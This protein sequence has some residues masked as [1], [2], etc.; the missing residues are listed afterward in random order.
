MP[1]GLKSVGL[2]QGVVP[3]QYVFANRVF[4]RVV[5]DPPDFT[6][7]S[8]IGAGKAVYDDE[9]QRFLLTARPRKA[10]GGVRGFAANIYISGDG[11]EFTLLTSISQDEVSECSGF[12]VHSIEGTQLLRD[13]LTGR[14]HL[15]LSVDAGA[16]FIWGGL[17]WQTLLLTSTDLT[18]PW[19]AEGLVLKN[20]Q[21]YDANQARDASID[22]IDGRWVCMYKAM[23][24]K[25]TQRPALAT[26]VDGIH[27][28]KHGP[29]TIDGVDQPAFLNG[30]MFAGTNGPLFMGVGRLDWSVPEGVKYADEYRIGHAD[31]PPRDFVAYSLDSRNLDLETI[32]R[33]PWEPLS[34][35]EHREHPL[36]GYGSLVFDP[37]RNR[38]LIYVEAI[39]GN[40][41]KQIG[42]NE[43]VERLL[44]YETKL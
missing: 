35:Y 22:I 7:G 27:W 26:S 34:P 38:M 1:R 36:L 43:T 16:D 14:W 9:A 10:A 19:R 42:L 44:L 3:A 2:W 31:G 18:G 30:S 12:K 20:D 5:L 15:Y 39:D 24:S 21:P 6:P 29:L 32:F 11:E 25:R 13:P 28:S 37:L 4:K 8:W 23:D 41:T 40:L 33:A 17:Y